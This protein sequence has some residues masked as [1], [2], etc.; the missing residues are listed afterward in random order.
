MRRLRYLDAAKD[1]LVDIALYIFEQ[2]GSTE[3]ARRL[4]GRLRK[5]CRDIADKPFHLGRPRNELGDAIRS[6]A[7]G[8][9]IIFFRYEP[10]SVVIIRIIEGHRDFARRDFEE[11]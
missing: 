4:T 11:S 9:H 3:L 1:D 6:M 7:E 8:N 5:R 10:D 2:S